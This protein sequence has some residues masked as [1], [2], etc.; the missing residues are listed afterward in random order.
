MLLKTP[1]SVQIGD[2]I[3]GT[4]RAIYPSGQ[5]VQGTLVVSVSLASD[6]RNAP[7]SHTQTQTIEIY[8]ST[9]F[10][11]S[12]HQVQ[13]L[14]ES[15]DISRDLLLHVSACVTESSTGHK[16]D[17][18]AAVHL[19]RDTFQLSFS[20]VPLT[21]KPSLHFSSILRVSRYDG[22]PL[23][24]EDLL[25]SA[26]IEVTQ[27]TP[28]L[29]SDDA[30]TL[31]LPVPEDG[32]VHLKIP[33]KEEAVMLLIRA[34]FQSTEETLQVN[35]SF[36]SPSG[37]YL[38]ISP[39]SS[40]PAQVGLPLQL[41]VHSTVQVNKL[42]F[43]V[44]SKGQVLAAGTKTSSTF[45]LMPAL[46]WC[47]ES[48][49]TVYT[50]LS[51][52]EV[53]SDT[54]HI[55]IDQHG[56]VSLDWSSN[57]AQPGEQVSL[58][59]SG[60]EPR[61]Q[62]AIIAVGADSELPR[63]DLDVTVEQECC[64]KMVTNGILNEKR[65][66]GGLKKEQDLLL[67]EKRWSSWLSQHEFFMWMDANVSGQTQTE[68]KLTVPRGVT[69][70][71][72]VALVMSDNLGL[73]FTPLSQELSVSK[74]FSLSLDVPP[75]LIRGEEIVL[76]V[77]LINHLEHE[78]EVILLLAQSE[79]F[80]FVL[81]DRGD[82]SV[83]NAQ[84]F[85]LGSH[86]STAALFPIRPVA[87]GMMAISV[88]AVSAE[89]SD[90]LIWKVLV[91]PGGVQQS[92]SESLFL[93]LAPVRQNN[94]RSVSFSF[95]PHVVEGSQ[96]GYVALVGDILALSI[97]HLDSLVELPVGCG[98]QNMVLFA[99]SI[100]V[101]QY[102]DRSNQDNAEI[103]SRALGYMKEGYE[104]QLTYQRDDGSFSAFGSSDTSGSTWLTAFVLRCFLQAQT[105]VQ[106][107]QRVLSR[108]VTWLLRQ[109]GPQGEF[110]EAGRVIHTEMQGGLDDDSAGLTAYV[111][112]ALLEDES[113][114][115][116][117]PGNVSLART[118]LE[119]RVTSGRLSN[120]SLCLAAYA[121]VLANSPV[122]G[123]ALNELSRRA[124]YR[125]GVMMWS[126]SAGLE[127]HDWQPRSAQI[128]M[129]SYVLM[130]F[131]RRGSLVEGI[132]LMKWLSGQRNHLGG[133][134]TTQDTVIALQ[135]LA[136]YAAI[137]GANAIDLRLSISDP[138][139]SFSVFHINASNFLAYQR[140]EIDIIKDIS[141]NIYM[142]GRGFAVL[143]T[144][145]F[146]NLAS[147]AFLQRSSHAR[148]D[149]AFS[150][151]VGITEAKD[152]NHLELSI[153]T[154]LKDNQQVPSTGM[155]ILD[156][157]MLSGFRFP[158]VDGA[159]TELIRRVEIQPERVI[160]YLD[161][162]TKSKV[163][164]NFSVFRRYKVARVQDAVVQ[165]YDY[166][167]PTRKATRTYN[168]DSLR[169]ADSCSF[170]GRGCSRCRPG[171]A[172]T[173]TSSLSA[174]SFGDSGATCSWIYLL[175]VVR[176]FLMVL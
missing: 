160:F 111:L 72:A 104:R 145:I 57:K 102:L 95:P 37:S 142:E 13:S 123:T 52:G 45:S 125:D 40:T 34:N 151:D 165:V 4:V 168:S 114:V 83:V 50:I 110:I 20:H 94:S 47:P 103:R 140:Q 161:S 5:P 63:T 109:Q 100:Y 167:E 54:A 15:S 121:L 175:L 113:N 7:S 149:E 68:E 90:S 85:T 22:R 38:Q 43:V 91:K 78:I 8:G 108:A 134:G 124:D 117:Y 152:R 27:R 71:R 173:V 174:H 82:V 35:N 10:S 147:E 120:Y 150:L 98:E 138:A 60:L 9:R 73:G 135:A 58:T 171:V 55:P 19:A 51:D 163:C 89:A 26:V 62:F 42:H 133:Y 12:N 155:A 56:N 141:L 28:N 14:L 67:V 23:S 66:P 144:N 169:E 93:E 130:A 136:Y 29:E 69:S 139:S 137:S 170:C 77:N 132:G 86:V 87:L 166:Y 1:S 112:M 11:F 146:Y 176:A 143:Q 122:A 116:M 159:P 61:S 18:A 74:D 172:L 88:D 97:N 156:V 32:N 24:S 79:A 153:C 105:Y 128:E 65:Q 81:A 41:H 46:S 25:Y 6:F 127:S 70:L 126:S 75:Y 48:C 30:T 76:E 64:V 16:V 17:K 162:V 33:V 106:I 115:D 53:V 80:E 119:D 21:L 101:L 44:S 92:Y 129:T 49:V 59:V 131:F 164:I 154:R 36:F 84:K 31:T 158:A 39:V 2:D 118:Y 148:D 157:G 99:P 3:S 96:R 107:N